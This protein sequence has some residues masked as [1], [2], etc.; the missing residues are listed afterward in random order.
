[1]EY[2]YYKSKKGNFGDDLNGWLWPQ[3]FGT[4]GSSSDFYFVGIGSLLHNDSHVVKGLDAGRRKVVFGTGVKPSKVYAKMSLDDT[5]DV[6]FLRGP[7]SSGELNRKD[8]YITDAAYAIRL[9]DDFDKL[10]QQPKKYKISLMP[11]FH[12]T[13]YFDWQKICDQLGYHYISPHS[14]KG[15]EFTLQEIAASECLITEAMHGAIMADTLRVPWHRFILSTPHTEGGRISDFKW[16]DWLMSIDIPFPQS[17]YIPFYQMGPIGK[18][19]KLLTKNHVS[20]EYLPKQKVSKEVKEKLKD[21]D[22][23]YLSTDETIGGIDS[24]IHQKIADF[25]AQYL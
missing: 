16:T 24:K 22:M 6:M 8:P 23:F 14:E 2:L 21:I 13:D 19:T 4:N 17:T 7:L 10:S 11:Y 18:L 1:M 25:K 3:L 20:L 5:W 12:S 9:L 15:V